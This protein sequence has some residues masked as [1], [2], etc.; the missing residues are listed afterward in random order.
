MGVRGVACCEAAAVGRGLGSVP[1]A[2]RARQS[3][4]GEGEDKVMATVGEGA[5][6]GHPVGAAMKMGASWGGGRVVWVWVW[7]WAMSG[8]WWLARVRVLFWVRGWRED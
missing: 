8:T 7:G 6:R 2:I 5:R 1:T 3:V 4:T